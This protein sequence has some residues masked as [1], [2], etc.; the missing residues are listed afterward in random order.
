MED[1]FSFDIEDDSDIDVDDDCVSPM[2]DALGSILSMEDY[3][4]LMNKEQP[5]VLDWK[6]YPCNS[7]RLQNLEVRFTFD[8]STRDAWATAK[9]EIECITSAARR[10]IGK[11]DDSKPST[12]EIFSI[13]FGE[14]SRFARIMMEKLEVDY[15]LLLKWLHDIFLQSIYSGSTSSLY[16]SEVF[17]NHTL[18]NEGGV[19]RYLGSASNLRPSNFHNLRSKS[20]R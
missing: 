8:K 13:F 2:F 7:D 17:N 16:K 10:L 4:E 15:V 1:I 6:D 3:K 11:Y 20:T 9:D 5:G 12:R 19:L 14:N 18:L